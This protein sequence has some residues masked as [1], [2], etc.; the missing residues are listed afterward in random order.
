PNLAIANGDYSCDSAFIG[1]ADPAA[2][3]SAHECLSKLRLRIGERFR[4]VFGD[5]DPGKKSLCSGQGGLRLES[6][7]IAQAALELQP[8]WTARVGRYLLVGITS[9]LAAMPVFRK[10]ALPEEET[11][12]QKE[13]LE[14]LAAIEGC[15]RGVK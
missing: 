2:R 8:F 4:A 9:T 1:V 13:S 3:Q 12:W 15:F 7:R 10:E 6:L 5:H 11:E 14:H